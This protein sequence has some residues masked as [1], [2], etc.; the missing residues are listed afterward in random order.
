M[1]KSF[2]ST[3]Q[4]RSGWRP[5]TIQWPF[6]ALL[7]AFSTV[8]IIIIEFLVHWS[9]RDGGLVFATSVNSLSLAKIFP[10][11]HLPT[12]IAVLYAILWSW[13]DLDTRRLEPYFQLSKPDGGAK[14]YQSLLLD[15]PV[16][17]LAWVP[18]RAF[19]LGYVLCMFIKY[20]CQ[21]LISYVIG[22]GQFSLDRLLLC[23]HHG[24]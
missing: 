11:Q 9:Q 3:T 7:A 1:I 14:G 4:D 22:T 20:L 23:Y 6:L 5:I 21:L 2:A 24:V 19:R 8:L 15:Y 18:L 17:F 10:Y 16:D 13:V 12:I